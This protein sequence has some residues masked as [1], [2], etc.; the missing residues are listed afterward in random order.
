LKTFDG[1]YD[2]DGAEESKLS[3]TVGEYEG[4]MDEVAF[5]IVG[6]D[7][8]VTHRLLLQIRPSQQLALGLPFAPHY[9]AVLFSLA[10]FALIPNDG[11]KEAVVTFDVGEEESKDSSRDGFVDRAD[12]GEALGE[13]D[14]EL[15][16]GMLG[17]LEG[18]SLVV[19]GAVDGNTEGD[20][21]GPSDD[22]SEGEVDGKPDGLEDGPEEGISLG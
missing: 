14:G 18:I 1:L 19:I 12:D 15:D 11:V 22:S 4:V 3:D 7:G 21:L 6:I 5:M 8:T 2:K 13:V 17:S 20:S 9:F 10:H 16:G